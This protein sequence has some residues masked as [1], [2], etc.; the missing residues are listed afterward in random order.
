MVLPP[1]PGGLS[2]ILLTLDFNVH[3]KR[4]DDPVPL[5]DGDETVMSDKDPLSSDIF[6]KPVVS[7]LPFVVRARIQPPMEQ[8]YSG[9]MIDQDHLVGMRVR[10]CVLAATVSPTE[11]PRSLGIILAM[12]I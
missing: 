4:V 7:K 6:L 11:H 10:K 9:Y 1:V 12:L 2:S 5:G 8:E 3:L